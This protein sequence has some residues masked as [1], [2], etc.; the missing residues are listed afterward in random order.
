MRTR[1]DE[2]F[3]HK[4]VDKPCLLLALFVQPNVRVA[5]S[6]R[7]KR[8]CENSLMNRVR[9]AIRGSSHPRLS[10]NAAKIAD[11]VKALVPDNWSPHFSV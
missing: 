3:K 8:R 1:T 11:A 6:K 5:C 2:R 9:L 7:S 10:A 4:V